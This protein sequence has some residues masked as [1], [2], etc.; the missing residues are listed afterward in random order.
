MV[1]RAW[2]GERFWTS[3]IRGLRNPD[4]G[5]FG[6]VCLLRVQLDDEA[7]VDRGRQIGAAGHGLERALQPLRIDLQPLGDAARL[8][9][10][11]GGLDAQLLL[12]L[13]GH[14]HY[15]A[16]THLERRDVD[17]LAVHQDAVMAHHLARL[18]ARS[19]EAH[20]IGH[21]VEAR[22][23]ELQQPLA[24]HALGARSLGVG[25]AELALEHAVDAAQLLLLAQLL[26]VVGEPRA[27]L[28]AVLARGVG[29]PFDGAFVGEALLALQ[30][31]LFAFPAALA[32]LGVEDS[33]HAVSWLDAPA[34][35]RTATVVRNRGH[36]GDAGNL[37]PDRIER[38]HRRFSPRAG[39]LDADLDVLHA[40][41]LRRAPGALGR[42]LRRERRRLARSLE[43][44]VP[45]GRPGKSVALP[46]GDGDDGVVERRVHVRD[47]LGDVFLD[48]FARARRRR[49][50]KLL[51]RR[52]VP[53]RHEFS[54]NG[55]LG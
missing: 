8:R 50:L 44:G 33:C 25:L 29:A 38:P 5:M 41:F 3:T 55:F 19:A 39:A 1:T 4:W 48:L 17:A 53:A 15:V 32:A 11:G 37:Q 35:R 26:A 28:L 45:R 10:L 9:R 36:V 22:F 46:V 23:E 24:G 47:A 54:W 31:Q 40:A 43:P 27:A 12:G 18:G 42:D 20:A 34:L 30:E 6:P 51:P 16:G 2:F 21:G 49:L 7:F 13:A 14:F 52:S